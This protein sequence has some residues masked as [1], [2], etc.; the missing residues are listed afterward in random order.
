[1]NRI[2]LIYIFSILITSAGIYYAGAQEHSGFKEKIIQFLEKTG[3]ENLSADHII[4][5]GDVFLPSDSNDETFF[6]KGEWS[7]YV[8]DSEYNLKQ[9]R[10]RTGNLYSNDRMNINAS[11]TVNVNLTYGKSYYTSKKYMQYDEDLPYSRVIDTGFWPEQKTI[12]NVEGTIGDRVTVFIDHDSSREENRYIMNYKAVSDDEIIRE[13]NAGEI[14]IKFNHSKYAVYDNTD[15]KGLGVDFTLAKGDFSIKAFGSIARGEAQVEYFRGNSSP[16][17]TK[18]AE[19]QYV[20]GT[21][22]QLEPFIRYD[23]VTVAPS[24][25]GAYSLITFTSNPANPLNYT[26]TPVNIS[27]SDFEIYIDDQNQY[28]NN[29]AI[30]LPYDGGYYTR[31]VNGIDYSINF[32]TGVIRFLKEFPGSSRIFAAYKR[33]GGTLDPCALPSG[34]GVFS[35]RIFVFLKYGY[36]INED[37]DKDFSL[38]AGEDKNGDGRL[39]LDIYE[40]RS[41]YFLGNR[42]ILASDFSIDF[43]KENQIM[44]KDEIAK[45]SSYRLDLTEGLLLFST[46]ES[47]KSLLAPERVSRIYS[48]K[49]ISDAYL[50]SSYRLASQYNVEARAFKLKNG[51]IIDKSVRIK[52]N[53][54]VIS[55]SLYSVD[56]ESGFINFSDPNNPVISSDSKIEIKYEYIPFGTGDKNFIGG[57][58]ADYDLNKSLRVGGTIM[59]SRDGQTEVIPDIGNV[60]EQTLLFEGDAA[61]KL[62]QERMADLYNIFAERK[63]KFIPVEFSAYA[64]YAKSIKDVNIF[65]KALIDNMET[66]DEIVSV[67]LSE[68]DWI[69]SSMPGPYSQSD[70]GLL[71]YYFYR[72]PDSPESL[73]G[74]GFTPYGVPYD[75]K[76]GP[77]NIATGHVANDILEQEHQKSLVFDFN[78][79]SGQSVVSA[80]TRRL[81]ETAIDLSGMQYVEVWVKYE[82]GTDPV[83]LHLDFGT[84]NE[85]SDGDGVLDTED[86]NRNGYIDSEPSSGYSEDRGY[87]FNPSGGTSTHVGSGPGLSS[88]TKG[89]GALTSEDLDANGVLDTVNNVYTV[90]MGSIS[91]AAGVWQ[92]IRV[93]IDWSIVSPAQLV[94]LQETKSIRLYLVGT[95]GTAGRVSIDTLKVVSSKWKNPE[96]NNS[97]PITDPAMMK[98]TL[99]NSIS[100]SDYRNDSFLIREPGLYKELYGDDSVDDIES[101]SETAL[102]IEYNLTGTDFAS[103]TRRFTKEIDIRFY[104]TMNIWYNSRTSPINSIGFIIGSSDNDFI[105]YR[106]NP[107]FAMVWK[108]IKL[109]LEDDSAGDVEKFQITGKPDL[110]RIKYIKAVIHSN[111]SSGKIWLNEIY[112]SEPEKLHGDA[113]WY[114]FELKALQPLFRTASGVPVLSDMNLRYIFKGH[115]S[116]FNSVNKTSADISENYHELFASANVLPNWHTNIN[117]IN[118][119]SRTDS[120]NEKVSDLKKGDARR[121]F[122]TINSVFNSPGNGIP[123][124]T[125][126]YSYDKNENLREA[127]TEGNNYNEDT[128]SVIHTPVLLYRQELADFLYGK[129]SLRMILDMAFSHKNIERDSTDS[130]NSMLESSV[131]LRESEKKQESDAK[132]ELDY[133]NGLFYFRPQITT[134]SREYVQL[135]GA[136]KY[137][138]T[139]VN[140]SVNGNF[141]IPFRSS[142]DSKFIER[143]NGSGFAFGL[144]FSEYFSPEY[145]MSIDYKEN[146]F[147]DYKDESAVGDGFT[148]Y[149]NSMSNLTSEIRLPVLLNKTEKFKRVK[150]LNFSYQ[151]SLYFN[152]ADVPYEG[153]GTGYFAEEYGISNV[154]S[155]LGSPAYNLIYNY[156][157]IYLQ[158]RGNAG[159]GRDLIHGV[160][161]DDHG[162]AGIS[163]SSEYNNSLKLI[164]NLNADLSFDADLFQFYT[165]GSISQVCERSNIYGI[166][167][168]VIIGDSSIN[169]EFDLMQIFKTGFFRG[170][171]EGLP[172]HSSTLDLGLNFTDSMLITQNINEKKI[173]PSTGIFFKWDR[174]S[175][176]F[177]YEFDFRVKTNEEYISTSLT[178]GDS[179]YIYLLNMEGNSSF[180]E[181][182]YGHKFMSRYETD[183]EWLYSFF[184]G[185]YKLT[186]LPLFS[187]EYKMEINRYDYFKTVSPE[188]Y[189]LFMIISDLN[190]DLHKNVQGSVSGKMALEKFR[191]RENKGISR[192]VFSYE[193]NTGISFIF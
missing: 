10:T 110:K 52:I 72:D 106:V 142:E 13:I 187:V 9:D 177:K 37:L 109:K 80:V 143:N 42:Q 101:E 125:L 116:Q 77:F 171:G 131:A 149:K 129:V 61:L 78:F 190:L 100:D 4:G 16:G 48:E 104:K 28:N 145:S 6:K 92:K 19:Y 8:A 14:D 157:G 139:G 91:P 166:P 74:E 71:N 156:P 79:S 172:Y 20:S 3:A 113:K 18:I 44:E 108:E 2:F 115:S 21:Y 64:E 192:Q 5:Q 130:N 95:S 118:E 53:E 62:T 169:F 30:V 146:A 81:T 45:L 174:S 25:A 32:S 82:A 126:A 148:R 191:N 73:K 161:N 94:A 185:F 47:F 40:I 179:D 152:E 39:N 124:V 183:V 173:G 23:A 85:D 137:D 114:E 38:D 175:I 33:N 36:S 11:G 133:S 87:P 60:S 12:L 34:P 111:G 159:N 144:K 188:P 141:Y 153:E 41:V 90:N 43:Y 189:D 70:R 54:V 178:E 164:D 65:G 84:V 180:S 15:A 89:D 128:F 140:G 122:F 99:V 112:V 117:Y 134:S 136:D 119:F 163:S 138:S 184:S 31:M 135:D 55:S 193:V 22:Y 181:K 56:Y 29:N 75:V 155:G 97:T 67:S 127:V 150:N 66:S 24:G 186:G 176:S 167:N 49:K 123:S 158:G 35:G 151:R 17:S 46:R 76:P 86:A 162:I 165:S 182:D 103:I 132:V 50:Y 1:M 27:P 121:D 98:I 170:N 88:F 154:F 68:K 26:L 7:E 102:Q 57:V 83:N 107:D 59:F 168:Q 51:N 147:K 63:K 69:L 105:E 96:L 120:L 160:F 58:R 93:H